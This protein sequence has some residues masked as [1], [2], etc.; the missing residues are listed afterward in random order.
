MATE[1]NCR[2]STEGRGENCRE[3][4]A[5]GNHTGSPEVVAAGL[6]R[7][8]A[9]ELGGSRTV[10]N[11]EGGGLA[12]VAALSNAVAV[13]VVRGGMVPGAKTTDGGGDERSGAGVAAIENG[14]TGEINDGLTRGERE[15]AL[16]MVAWPRAA[17]VA[18]TTRASEPGV[19]LGCAAGDWRGV[20]LVHERPRSSPTTDGGCDAG[21]R[22]PAWWR[23]V[24]RM[25]DSCCG[26]WVWS[27][28]LLMN[29]TPH[30]EASSS[31]RG[32]CVT[33]GG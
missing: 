21:G 13:P 18:R 25:T 1:C 17:W 24:Q 2:E 11:H 27:N 7:S 22:E 4:D 5:A 12:T 6:R 33:R 14:P 9:H 15:T 31:S 32:A 23:P 20:H 30:G 26:L 10:V 16:A 8:L 29:D 28:G 19:T 3:T